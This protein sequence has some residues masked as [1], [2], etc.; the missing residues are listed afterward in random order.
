MHILVCLFYSTLQWFRIGLAVRRLGRF[1]ALRPLGD[2]TALNALA[3]ACVE[4]LDPFR[5]PAGEA[6]LA[7]RRANG[8]SPAQD[9]NLMRWG[10]PFVMDQFRFHITL[11]GR[12]SDDVLPEVEQALQQA[13][14]PLLP[15][16][17]TITDLALA[18]EAE[19][20][21]FHL[22]HRYTLSG[23]SSDSAV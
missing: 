9:A 22:I 16:P 3:A 20:G 5:A 21:Q 18:G 23:Q 10:Y 4:A 1:L 17:F 11:T 2:E 6:E 15:R 8:L 14:T 12:L 7:R 13:L 19:D